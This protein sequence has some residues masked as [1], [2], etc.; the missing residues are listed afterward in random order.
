M[1]AVYGGS[2]WGYGVIG[3][4][5]KSIGVY[6]QTSGS[7]G[8]A[9]VYGLVAD[10]GGA[11]GVMGVSYR[12]NGVYGFTS[13]GIGVVGVAKGGKGVAIE[14]IVAAGSGNAIQG[15]SGAGNAVHGS[16][17]SGYGRWFKGKF[18][19]HLE[20][21]NGPPGPD[22]ERGDFYADSSGGLWFCTKGST[23]DAVAVWKSVAL[24]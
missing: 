6:G 21:G 15:T 23:S 7:N 24:E 8:W 12:A 9:A 14:G 4:S 10:H 19:L 16:S 3:E 5:T 22:G 2:R 1:A 11:T 13:D 17:V 18:P 20:P